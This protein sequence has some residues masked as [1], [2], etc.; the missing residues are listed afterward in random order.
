MWLSLPLEAHR[1]S[2]NPAG[3]LE[4]VKKLIR[5]AYVEVDLSGC[6]TMRQGKWWLVA[7]RV[8]R[9]EHCTSASCHPPVS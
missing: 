8:T 3:A 5:E 9:M 6:V 7:W 2:S 1:W 4:K